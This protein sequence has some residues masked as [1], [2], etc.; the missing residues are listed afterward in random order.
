MNLVAAIAFPLNRDL[1]VLSWQ[2]LD[3][4]NV[5]IAWMNGL[6][7]NNGVWIRGGPLVNNA[8]IALSNDTTSTNRPMLV[9]SYLLPCGTTAPP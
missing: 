5:A 4:I 9:V 8:Q 3:L 6:Y 2:S 1:M 7:P